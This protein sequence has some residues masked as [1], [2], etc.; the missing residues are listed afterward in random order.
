MANFISAHLGELAALITSFLWSGTSTFF[1]IGGRKVGSAVVNRTRVIFALGFLLLAHLILGQSLPTYISSESLLWLVLS[2][3]I[4]LAVG[5][6]FLFQGFVLVGPRIS[7]LMM[8]LAPVIS[9]IGAWIFLDEYLSTGQLLGVFLTIAG[10]AW[11][12]LDGKNGGNGQIERK[13]FLLG[14][15]FA[16]G[17]AVGQ[18]LS[19]V[20]AKQGMIGGVPALSAT[21]IRM[22]AAAASLWIVAIFRGQVLPTFERLSRHRSAIRYIL[23]G[24]FIGPFL[25]VTFSL[26]AVQ[27][28]EVGIASALMALPPVFLLPISYFVFGERFG[29]QAVAGTLVAV[30]GVILLFIL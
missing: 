18:A 12:V 11:V 10:I 21:L 30:S 26:I 9:V 4:G 24:A 16:F 29:W 5:D 28:T 23:A 3:V 20:A 15:M 13:V 17:G 25:G 14:V 19:L 8:S 1:T 6:A 2:G 22:L 27:N 7:M